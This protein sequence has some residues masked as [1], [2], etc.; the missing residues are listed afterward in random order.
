[1]LTQFWYEYHSTIQFAL[2][3]AVFAISVYLPMWGGTLSL[4]PIAIGGVAAYAGALIA[5]ELLL[6]VWALILSGA[7]VGA[8][9]AAILWYPLSRIKSHFFLL[10]TIC[11]VLVLRVVL[12]NL[13][14]ITG[15][16]GGLSVMVLASMPQVVVVLA[17]C[18][19]LFARL[20]R[21]PYGMALEAIR[22][23]ES[24]ARVI[25]VGPQRIRQVAF[26]GSGGLAGIAG[27]MLASSLGFITPDTFFTGLAFAL[28][29]SVVLGG[30]N[31]WIG[32]VVGA[33]LF[34][35]L[36]ELLREVLQEGREVASGV[37]LLAVVIL[38][39]GGLVSLGKLAER[40]LVR[41]RRASAPGKDSIEARSTRRVTSVPSLGGTASAPEVVCIVAGLGKL[42]GGLKALEDVSFEIKSHRVLGVVGPN[43]AGKSTLLNIISAHDSASRGDIVYLGAHRQGAAAESLAMK[44]ISRTFQNIR[45]FDNLNVLEQVGFALM[46]QRRESTLAYVF[47]PLR[48]R[49]MLERT[50]DEATSLLQLVGFDADPKVDAKSL[51]YGQQRRVELARALAMQPRLLL[52]DEPTAGMTRVEA[53]ELGLLVRRLCERGIAVVLV[54]HNLDLVRQVCDE[55]VVLNFGRVI[56]R[57]TAE[58]ALFADEVQEAYLGTPARA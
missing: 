6:D 42:Y 48:T 51:S 36:P 55:V 19:L 32:P 56:A 16:P 47:R 38:L 43:G 15:G 9:I 54:E 27:V 21:S 34:T 10:A 14:D 7:A 11:M 49:R 3:Y 45:L 44:G 29:A 13:S 2:V 46:R 39:P 35:I 28:I 53:H 12:T 20:H 23:D 4:A 1:M 18:L 24:A 52:L 31:H 22:S 33:L 8:L 26:V 5:N 37:V 40:R 30:I 17:L 57:G 25:G 58:D 41:G 50:R